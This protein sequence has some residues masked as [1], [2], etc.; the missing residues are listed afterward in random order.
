MSIALRY[1]YELRYL[2]LFL[3]NIPNELLI[4]KYILTVSLIKLH[5]YKYI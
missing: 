4:I 3:R 5:F 2:K 1:W